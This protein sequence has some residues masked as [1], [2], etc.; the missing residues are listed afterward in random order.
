VC[1]T[2]AAFAPHISIAWRKYDVPLMQKLCGGAVS[3][4]IVSIPLDSL[5]GSYLAEPKSW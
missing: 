2:R 5:K 4:L 3:Y 1:V